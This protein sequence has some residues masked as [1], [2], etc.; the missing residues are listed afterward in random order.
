MRSRSATERPIGPA[1]ARTTSKPGFGPSAA[2]RTRE[3]YQKRVIRQLADRLRNAE[4]RTNGAGERHAPLARLESVDAAVRRRNAYAPADVQADS[5]RGAV[6]C[7][8]R[9]LAARG[10][11]R[12]V[13][14]R[15]R[16][17][18]AAPERVRALKGEQRL[19]HVRLGEDDGACCTQRRDDLLIGGGT[20][21]IDNNRTVRWEARKEGK[22]PGERTAPSRLAGSFAHCVYPIVLSKPLTS[23]R[24]YQ[25]EISLIVSIPIVRT[26]ASSLRRKE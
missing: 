20:I 19:R 13:C 2:Q 15:P 11:A 12:G 16:V 26:R 17:A 25:R 23:T 3:K 9:T 24:N 14:G 21:D 1:T 22:G 6:Y 8:K 18:R 5:E 4:R 10:A 7:D